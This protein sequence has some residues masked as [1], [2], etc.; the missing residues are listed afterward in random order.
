MSDKTTDPLGDLATDLY[1][2]GKSVQ[3]A[4]DRRFE[5][6]DPATERTIATVADASVSDA[7]AAIDAAD[8][9]APA[10]AATPP[11]Q[12]AEILRRAFDLSLRGAAHL[13]RPSSLSN[14]KALPYGRGEVDPAPRPLRG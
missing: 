6:V 8:E 13:A 5:V 1:I 4:G 12:R 2:G 7:I 14:G 10:W 9:A 11:R 3:A